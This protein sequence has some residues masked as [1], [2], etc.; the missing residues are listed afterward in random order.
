MRIFLVTALLVITLSIIFL[1]A[2]NTDGMN[3]QQT[4]RECNK[5]NE[6]ISKSHQHY[7]LQ[8]GWHIKSKCNTSKEVVD[9]YPEL[10]STLQ[11]GGLNLE[12]Y[13]KKGKE[14]TITTYTLK[15]EQQNG[16]KLSATIYE[17]DGKLIGGYGT[18]ENWD[19]GI[20]SLSEK[21]RLIEQ[22]NIMGKNP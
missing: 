10:I 16:D 17:I 21:E 7:L 19:P 11:S 5:K 15:E 18:L 22:G 20:F 13:N 8:F 1:V 14:A 9:Y 2:L 4:Y 12:P 3:E 6:T